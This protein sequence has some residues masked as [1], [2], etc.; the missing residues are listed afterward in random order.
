MFPFFGPDVGGS[1][2]NAALV[3]IQQALPPQN[4]T[5]SANGAGL[6]FGSDSGQCFAIQQ[7]GQN[8]SGT[9]AG[10]IQQSADNSTWSDIGGAAFTSVT[11]N[12]N[13]QLIGFTRSQRYL[14]YVATVSGSPLTLYAAASIAEANQ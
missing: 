3:A 5:A 12:N 8:A 7:V 1:P 10:K 11:G 14:R 9:L 6:D 13:L 2:F 4:L